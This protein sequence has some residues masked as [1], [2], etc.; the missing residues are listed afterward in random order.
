MRGQNLARQARRLSKFAFRLNQFSGILGV[1]DNTI[2][3]I[4]DFSKGNTNRA[5]VQT[6]QALTYGAGLV[7]L[8]IPGTQ[9]LGAVLIF[10]AG[11]SDF[12]EMITG[13]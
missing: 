11:A 4:N 3:S 6:T 12:F 10:A 1:A 9:P 2:Q 13:R 8:A 7:L 5:I